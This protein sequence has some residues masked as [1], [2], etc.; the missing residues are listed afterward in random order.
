VTPATATNVAEPTNM[1]EP[2]MHAE[3]TSLGSIWNVCS[4]QRGYC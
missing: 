4:Q 3:P 2:T 1:A